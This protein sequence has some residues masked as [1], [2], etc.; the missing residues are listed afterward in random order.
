M[1][2]N[3]WEEWFLRANKHKHEAEMKVWGFEDREDTS[4]D[5]YWSWKKEAREWRENQD[6][7][8][9]EYPDFHSRYIENRQKPTQTKASAEANGGESSSADSSEF[10]FSMTFLYLVP[11][12]IWMAFAHGFD[13][14]FKEFIRIV[15]IPFKYI[16]AGEY[17]MAAGVV[18]GNIVA[19]LV[20][21]LALGMISETIDNG[22]WDTEIEFDGKVVFA[23]ILIFICFFVIPLSRPW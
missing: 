5:A 2:Y 22:V 17:W 6:Y 1:P 8:I 3:E 16:I 10:E 15:F 19:S 21:L 4:S 23:Y 7:A 11:S 20:L 18:A 14:R 9:S 13:Y 12:M